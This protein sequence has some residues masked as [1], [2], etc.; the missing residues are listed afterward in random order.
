MKKSYT[1]LYGKFQSNF[2][3]AELCTATVDRT[4]KDNLRQEHGKYEKYQAIGKCFVELYKDWFWQ[5][6][7]NN[8]SCFG[9]KQ[10]SVV[11]KFSDN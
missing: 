3:S 6:L 11:L 1:Y 2:R 7:L 8:I 5:N 9:I 4:Q 10:R